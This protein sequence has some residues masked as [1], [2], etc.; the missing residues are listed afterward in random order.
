[1][2]EI[3]YLVAIMKL[4]EFLKNLKYI[5]KPCNK[6]LVQP[7]CKNTCDK[8][9]KHY[10]VYHLIGDLFPRVMLSLQIIM[11]IILITLLSMET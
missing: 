6:C 3:I 5:R 11:L 4:I 2:D 7:I 10:E 8:L 9:E 1:M